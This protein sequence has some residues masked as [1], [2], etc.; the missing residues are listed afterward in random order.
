MRDACAELVEGLLTRVPA[1]NVLATSR[2]RLG[3]PG[4]VDYALEP[5]PVPD[6]DLDAEDLAESASVRLFFE[7]ASAVRFDFSATPEAFTA[8]AHI[9]RDL[10]GIPLA[11]ELAAAR[12]KALSADEIAANLD[13]RFDFLKFW[14]QIAVPRHQT[15][16]ATMDWSYDL[17]SEPEQQVLLRLSAFAGGFTISRAAWVCTDG[18]EH[19]AVDMVERLVE[20][21]LVVAGTGEG[22]TRYRQLETVRQY[23]AERL[24]ELGE[25]QEAS[26]AHADA[27]LRLAEEAFSPGS[28]GL[29]LLAR[30]LD[31]LRAALEWSFASG[32][33][34]GPRLACA[35]GRFW[36][37]RHHLAEGR[38]WLQRALELHRSE[39]AL[40]AE[41]LWLLGGLL[42]EI[43]DLTGAEEILS[44]GLRIA[45]AA[46][47]RT[48]AARIS[49]S[50]R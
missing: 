16:R 17:L 2:E 1:L 11:I 27:F 50:L 22:E 18:D 46:G 36:H 43:G 47:D 33:E 3:V 26:R 41:L 30:E 24:H 28:D 7:R 31:N 20:R 5:L 4:E 35:L 39:D 29:S 37:A 8:V 49:H 14:R 13:R 42:Q 15:L 12:T 9:C 44:E 25:A 34:T 6:P 23:A 32:V 48:C 40:R 38:A 19:R 45:D 21:S 10:D